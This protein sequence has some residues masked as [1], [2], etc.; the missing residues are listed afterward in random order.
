[1]QANKLWTFRATKDQL[2]S[3][4]L[5]AFRATAPTLW[6]FSAT[7]TQPCYTLNF[8]KVPHAKKIMDLYKVTDNQENWTALAK[9]NLALTNI[10][11]KPTFRYIIPLG[12][13]MTDILRHMPQSEELHRPFQQTAPRNKYFKEGR[14]RWQRITT[15]MANTWL[16]SNPPNDPKNDSKIQPSHNSYI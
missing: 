8:Y 10:T 4:S 9:D 6:D 15:A 14:F 16:S 2:S 11:E 5:W 3:T 12:W 1:M 13:D 7:I